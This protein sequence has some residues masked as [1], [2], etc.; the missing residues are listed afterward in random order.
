MANIVI[1]SVPIHGHVTP[2]LAVA[3]SLVERGHRVRFVTGARFADAVIST[4]SDFVALPA[5]ADY[6][7]RE[8]N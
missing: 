5:E 4:G 8:L 3:A 1:G 6:D 2:L 7:D